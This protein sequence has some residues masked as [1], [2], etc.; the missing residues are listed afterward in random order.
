[1][2]VPLPGRPADAAARVGRF[3]NHDK[4]LPALSWG[5]MYDLP[6]RTV[7]II[8]PDKGRVNY[9]KDQ[10]RKLGHAVADGKDVVEGMTQAASLPTPDVVMLADEYLAA[11]NGLREMMG[12]RQ[13]PV[14]LLT[15]SEAEGPKDVVQG[16]LRGHANPAALKLMLRNVLQVSE[17]KL[18]MDL[19]PKISV[20]AARAMAKITSSS[21]LS[22]RAAAPALRRVLKSRDDD[23]RVAALHALGNIAAEESTLDVLAVAA[24]KRA[25]KP[26]RLAALGALAKILEAQTQVPPDV[27]KELVPVSSDTDPEIALA[28]ARAIAVAKFNAGQFA[29]LMVL[30]RVKEIKSGR[31]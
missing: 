1:M 7:L 5:L 29:D 24:D 15:K 6:S 12:S 14:I 27:F 16:T 22:L 31:P 13:I 30:K 25:R 2:M 8:D 19:I 21:P 10:L 3:D 9:Y 4:V 11:A 20:R 17:L 18:V 26:V 28:A 23:V